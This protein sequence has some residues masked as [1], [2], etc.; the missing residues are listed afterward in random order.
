MKT[1]ILF[2]H[3]FNKIGW[4][5][6]VPSLVLGILNILNLLDFDF[7]NQ[8]TTFAIYSDEIM[9]PK[10]TFQC[11][12]NNLSD[13]ILTILNIVGAIFVAFSKE[14]QEDEFIVKLRLEALVWSVYLNYAV[15]IFFVIFF[16][17][18][19]FWYVMIFNLFAIL[20]LFI[21]RFNYLLLKLKK[22]LGHEE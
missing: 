17:G 22:S 18:S 2:P 11:I 8:S 21:F 4:F 16:Y 7:L 12:N 1:T 20:F 15:L 3:R 13:E 5:I 14:K 19:S 6:L 9:G 10:S